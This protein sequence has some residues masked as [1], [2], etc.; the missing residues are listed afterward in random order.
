MNSP[1]LFLSDL[2][3][4]LAGIDASGCARGTGARL[5]AHLRQL[6]AF[7]SAEEDA[8]KERQRRRWL[9]FLPA[10]QGMDLLSGLSDW[11]VG[12][13][14][15]RR[16]AQLD[17]FSRA[18]DAGTGEQAT[19]LVSPHQGLTDVYQERQRR[20][21]LAVAAAVRIPAFLSDVAEG[22]AGVNMYEVDPGV[23]KK[24]VAAAQKL[25][26]LAWGGA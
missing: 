11:L 20:H 25:D 26:A 16:E 18:G 22:L 12:C 23:T 7:A 10:V 15:A 4:T 6:D 9:T 2:A 17:A 8:R 1:F 19:V 14:G 5:A 21:R 3:D 13:E 24:I